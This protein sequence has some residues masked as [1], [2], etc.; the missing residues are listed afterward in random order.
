MGKQLGFILNQKR[1][2]GCQA[3]ET[4][5]Q[6]KNNSAVGI[7]LRT[8]ESYEHKTEAPYLTIGCV[9]CEKPACVEVCP[10]EAIT[11]REEDGV[12]I[13]DLSICIGCKS[14]VLACPYGAPKYNENT[15]KTEKC[16]FCHE[17]VANGEKPACVETCPVKALEFGELKDLEAKGGVKEGI[18]FI[19]EET[20]PSIRFILPNKK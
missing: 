3:C 13:T 14:C 15:N 18:N 2:I 6:V 8:A 12:V 16:D 10:V 5:C 11:K 19:V 20:G 17:R 4:A 9:H 7:S 1:C